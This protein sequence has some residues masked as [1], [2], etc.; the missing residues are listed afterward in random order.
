[1][2]FVTL[3]G[4]FLSLRRSAELAKLSGV[5]TPEDSPVR[6]TINHRSGTCKVI[7]IA[8]SR[9]RSSSYVRF[10]SN[11]KSDMCGSCAGRYTG[12]YCNL[13]I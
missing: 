13:S 5:S 8:Q 3:R 10:L 9:V 2:Q 12:P 7:A 11:D 6:A 4:Y 1:M